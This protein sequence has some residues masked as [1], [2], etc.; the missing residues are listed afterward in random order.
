MDR[1]EKER[2]FQGLQNFVNLE[3]KPQSILDFFQSWPGFRP[4][5]FRNDNAVEVSWGAEFHA[6]ALVFRDRLRDLWTSGSNES[7][8]VLLGTHPSLRKILTD[9]SSPPFLA[10]ILSRSGHTLL[11]VLLAEAMRTVQPTY[12]AHL[13]EVQPDWR[14]GGFLYSPIT[15]FQR[16]VSMLHHESWRAKVCVNCGRYFVADKSAQTYCSTKCTKDVKRARALEWWKAHGETWRKS[17]KQKA[18]GKTGKR[19][20]LRRKKP[21]KGGK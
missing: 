1:K 2:M 6:L 12:F 20:R 7:L 21:V 19:A 8:A 4:V 13:P 3:D 10:Q 18:Q 11:E 14:T 15:D 5:D 9:R 16:A 17:S